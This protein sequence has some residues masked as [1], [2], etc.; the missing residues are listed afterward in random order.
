M[1]K[2]LRRKR[3][4]NL[5]AILFAPTYYAMKGEIVTCENGH[6]ICEFSRNVCTRD[7]AKL[8]SDLVNWRQKSPQIGALIVSC[9][10]CGAQWWHGNYG[11]HFHFASGWRGRPP[12]SDGNAE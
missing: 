12:Y 10:R 5:N 3:K 1:F 9:E 8:D 6:E 4:S 11:Q 7:E 2:L